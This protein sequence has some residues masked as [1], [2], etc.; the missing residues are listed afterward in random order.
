MMALKGEQPN[1]DNNYS[2]SDRSSEKTID[3]KKVSG[4]EDL[5]INISSA[6]LYLYIIFAIGSDKCF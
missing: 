3:Q 1:N 5:S 2:P 6:L 4:H